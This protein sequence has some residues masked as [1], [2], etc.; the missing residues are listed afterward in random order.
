MDLEKENELIALSLFQTKKG[1]LRSEIVN[2][3]YKLS[4]PNPEGLWRKMYADG[5]LDLKED[6]TIGTKENPDFGREHRTDAIRYSL[7]NYGYTYLKHLWKEKE[8]EELNIKQINSSIIANESVKGT[9]E[10][11]KK[12]NMFQIASAITTFVIIATALFIQFMSYKKE[13]TEMQ[14]IIDSLQQVKMRLNKLETKSVAQTP[15]MN[16]KKD[17]LKK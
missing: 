13:K 12:T 17:S 10:S 14:P 6:E 8:I 5:Y 9:N 11:V 3:F 1:L 2:E 7:S 15:I 16:V 4:L